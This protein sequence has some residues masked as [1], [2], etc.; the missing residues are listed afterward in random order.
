MRPRRSTRSWARRRWWARGLPAP[1]HRRGPRAVAGLLGAAGHRQD[2]AR[3]HHRRRD[4]RALRALLGGHL[5][6]QGDQG[7][8][9]RRRAPAPGEGRRTLLFVDEIHRFNRA[10]QDAFLPYV[11]RGDIVLVGATTENPSFELNSALL[12]RCRVVVLEPL[13]TADLVACSSARSPTASAA[14]APPASR[15]ARRA[16]VDRAARLGRR[17]PRAQPARDGGRRHA[18]RRRAR[19]RG[20]GARGAAQGAALRQ[21]RRRALQPHLGAPQVAARERRR[22]RLYWLARMLE[23]GED[24]LYVARRMVRFASEDVGLADPQALTL[25]LH[26]GRPST[27][28]ARPKGDRAGA[29]RGLSRARAQEHRGLPRRGRR[30]PRGGGASRR[31][32]AA[33]HP[34]RADAADERARLR[35]RLRLRAGNRRR[36]R[37]ARVPTR[38]AAR[39]RFYHPTGHGFEAELAGAASC[40]TRCGGEKREEEAS[41]APQLL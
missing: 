34:Q 11:E 31:A 30:A 7:G 3:A 24:P 28:S 12:S 9:A 18:A 40:S 2:D 20:R 35:P 41:A 23:A 8:D 39:Q 27:A 25:A 13:A 10:Q 33:R 26:A 17:P 32:G 15:A 14:S 36:R 19:R 6:D 5:R 29:S 4:H 38:R 37:R 16:R 21:G 1:R 22:R